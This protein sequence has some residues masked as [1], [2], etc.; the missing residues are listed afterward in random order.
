MGGREGS[1][2]E[3]AVSARLALCSPMFAVARTVMVV[4]M[5]CSA[6]L[7][8]SAFKGCKLRC[9]DCVKVA[10]G[11][12]LRGCARGNCTQRDAHRLVMLSRWIWVE[13][14]KEK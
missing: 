3:T 12:R 14:S 4:H 5:V 6:L 11:S 8:G 1:W 7:G 13:I 2:C 10:L 9:N